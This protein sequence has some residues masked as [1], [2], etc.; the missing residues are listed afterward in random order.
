M[1]SLLA[2]LEVSNGKSGRSMAGHG[3]KLGKNEG[4]CRD[5]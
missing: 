1:R 2:G 4:F 3:D 5:A